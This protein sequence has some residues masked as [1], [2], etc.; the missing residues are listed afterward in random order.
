MIIT[1]PRKD[2]KRPQA[3]WLPLSLAA[4]MLAISLVGY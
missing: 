2:A 3:S 4:I 1:V